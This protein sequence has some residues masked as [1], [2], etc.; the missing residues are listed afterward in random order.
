VAVEKVVR[1]DISN[2]VVAEDQV[3]KVTISFGGRPPRQP[4][5]EFDAA[6][7]EIRDWIKISREKGR[8]RSRARRRTTGSDDE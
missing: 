5:R 1:S 2:E 4:P 8:G 3:V 7:N 6:E